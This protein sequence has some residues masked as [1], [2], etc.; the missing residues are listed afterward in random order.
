MSYQYIIIVNNK[1]F[2]KEFEIT[3]DIERIKL[4]TTSACEFRLNQDY[5]FEELE[6]ILDK[7][8]MLE[9]YFIPICIMAIYFRYIIQNPMNLH[10]KCVF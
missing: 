2:Y 9:S 10:F 3:D 1:S 7:E 8:E 6:L 5:F 4:G